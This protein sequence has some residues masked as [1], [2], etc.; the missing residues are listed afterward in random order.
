[1]PATTA[2][3]HVWPSSKRCKTCDAPRAYVCV[4]APVSLFAT[5]PR[6]GGKSVHLRLLGERTRCK[7]EKKEKSSLFCVRVCYKLMTLLPP[8]KFLPFCKRGKRG[9]RRNAQS[10]SPC[11]FFCCGGRTW[12]QKEKRT[13]S[14]YGEGGSIKRLHVQRNTKKPFSLLLTRQLGEDPADKRS[15]A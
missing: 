15:S 11:N 1:M 3:A 7:S 6:D 2:C 10:H 14:R 5:P 9:K 4:S 12:T 8:Q 13:F